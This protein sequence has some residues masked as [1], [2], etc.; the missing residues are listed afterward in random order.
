MRG[1]RNVVKQQRKAS[2]TLVKKRPHITSGTPRKIFPAEQKQ[3][4]AGEGGKR[5]GSTK[6]EKT[7]LNHAF[8]KDEKYSALDMIIFFSF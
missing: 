6:A 2:S 8:E 5:F 4:G 3:N 1:D 7:W